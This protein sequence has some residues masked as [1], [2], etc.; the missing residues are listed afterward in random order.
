MADHS[1]VFDKGTGTRSVNIYRVLA[2]DTL[3]SIA[4]RHDKDYRALARYNQIEAPYLLQPGQ[5]IQL[6]GRFVVGHN[7]NNK[8]ASAPTAQ[9]RKT[10]SKKTKPPRQPGSSALTD[11]W[12]WP[13]RGKVTRAFGKYNAGVDIEVVLGSSVLAAGSGEVVYAGQGLRG[14]Q[15]LIIIKHSDEI[16]S[17]Y[18]LNQEIIVREGQKIKVGSKLAD[19]KYTGVALDNL[20]FEIRKDG[21]PVNPGKFIKGQA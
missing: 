18:G 9:K 13:A 15:H 11:K 21:T 4:W 20:H 19:I 6:S 16:L 2:G 7:Q 14:F 10:S 1:P 3:Y 12:Q 5:T 17:A 8:P